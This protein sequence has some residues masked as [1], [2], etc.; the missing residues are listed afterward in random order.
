MVYV[1]TGRPWWGQWP[2]HTWGNWSGA[3]AGN[4]AAGF[5]GPF[6][7]Q[8][9][10]FESG[11]VRLAILSLL[12]EGPKHG[13]EIIKE[14]SARSGGLYR[15]SAGTVYPTLQLLDDQGLIESDREEGRRVYRL[16]AEGRTELARE[17]PEVERIWQRAAN[18]EDWSK[19][20]GPGAA[21]LMGPLGALMKA[22]FQAAAGANDD[23]ARMTR[24]REI[25]DRAVHDLEDLSR[26][27]PPPTV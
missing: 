18:W 4:P 22:A 6:G 13:Y 12:A 1:M 24:V 27:A 11:Q 23:A 14:L 2:G 21:L 3:Q 19:W 20:M 16:T 8:R 10:F 26:S 7:R 15:A 9:R 5:G 17:G 25:L